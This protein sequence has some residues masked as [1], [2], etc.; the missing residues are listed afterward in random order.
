MDPNLYPSS[1]PYTGSGQVADAP[2]RVLRNTYALLA[3]TMVP[4]IIG[5]YVGMH[6][7]M[8]FMQHPILASLL[9]MGG[10]MG[11][12]YGIAANR[13]SIIGVWLLLG[14]TLLLGWWLGPVLTIALALKNGPQ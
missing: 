8:I 5:A 3:L 10:V 13:N 2:N 14:M 9:M 11:M 4:T 1:R 12:Q 6:T 7:S